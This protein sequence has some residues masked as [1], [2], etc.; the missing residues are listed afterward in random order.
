MGVG[1][2]ECRCNGCSD[3]SI[4]MVKKQVGVWLEFILGVRSSLFWFLAY[5][6]IFALTLFY[7]L[8]PKILRLAHSLDLGHYDTD[9]W[10]SLWAKRGACQVLPW[11]RGPSSWHLCA[12]RSPIPTCL[13]QDKWLFKDILA[14]SQSTLGVR[15]DLLACSFSLFF[16]L[17]KAAACWE[18]VRLRAENSPRVLFIKPF[19][20][21]MYLW[22]P[23]CCF[24]RRVS[25]VYPAPIWCQN[26]NHQKC[27]AVY[28][29]LTHN[30]ES[31]MQRLRSSSPA[32]DS[33]SSSQSSVVCDI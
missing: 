21:S 15:G 23:G 8:G 17:L 20:T 13:S 22:A 7:H 31:K 10:V 6:I 1:T 26:Y 27:T 24:P 30:L 32:S 4:F 12:Q 33:S 29:G 16:L 18:G 3:I 14:H 2:S 28:N 25:L 9:V 19:R 5:L 11:D